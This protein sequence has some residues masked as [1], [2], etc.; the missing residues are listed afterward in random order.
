MKKFWICI[1]NIL[2]FFGLLLFN[3]V[4]IVPVWWAYTIQEHPTLMAQFMLTAILIVL[5]TG[6]VWFLNWYYQTRLAKN[7]PQGFEIETE[8]TRRKYI[9]W[10]V[11]TLLTIG[12]I[13]GKY[14]VEQRISP[15]AN[16]VATT[17]ILTAYPIPMS[18]ALTLFGP[19]GE[20]LTC[21]GLFFSL[22]VHSNRQLAVVSGW[23]SSS[24]LFALLHGVS[25]SWSTLIYIVTALILGLL[26]VLTR[27]LKYS[28]AMH[29]ALNLA[30]ALLS[31]T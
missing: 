27:K 1:L 14:I 5:G 18:V 10:S 21:R 6:T 2:I 20:E 7:N 31:F 30:A 17:D 19:I 3:R 25:F 13:V 22:F 16:T 28:I 15:N 12:M 26:Y 9:L 8:S 23:L 29:I 11:V 4:M 24:I